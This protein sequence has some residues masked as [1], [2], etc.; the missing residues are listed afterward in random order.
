[1]FFFRIEST[2]VMDNGRVII[3]SI[4]DPKGITYEEYHQ[5]DVDMVTAFP[6]AKVRTA[7]YPILTRRKE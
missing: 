2:A 5:L 4:S 6:N 3:K 7:G 1:M